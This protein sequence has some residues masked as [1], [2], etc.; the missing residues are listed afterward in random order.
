MKAC[1]A[2]EMTLVLS[3]S[4]LACSINVI[5]AASQVVSSDTS[6]CTHGRPVCMRTPL[7]SDFN[8]MMDHEARNSVIELNHLLAQFISSLTASLRCGGA[9][10]VG[11]TEFQIDLVLYLRFHSLLCSYAPPSQRRWLIVDGGKVHHVCLSPRGVHLRCFCAC[12]GVHFFSSS[13]NLR[14]SWTLGRDVQSARQACGDPGRD[15]QRVMCDELSP[16]PRNTGIAVSIIFR[17][18]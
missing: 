8:F 14:S 15:F 9:P 3:R 10:Y 4:P 7:W 12:R 2:H 1:E 6:E 18:V 5:A 11:I 16:L 13:S 17:L